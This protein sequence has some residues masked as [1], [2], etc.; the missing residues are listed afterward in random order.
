VLAT[1][2]PHLSLYAPAEPSRRG[3]DPVVAAALAAA[4]P[5]GEATAPTEA[6]PPDIVT[7]RITAVASGPGKARVERVAVVRT[8]AALANGYSVLAWGDRLD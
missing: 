3:T 5:P 7:A 4:A 6:A 8:G 1:L 2:R